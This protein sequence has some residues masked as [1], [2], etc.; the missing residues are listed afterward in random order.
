MKNKKR[1][2]VMSLLLIASIAA[3]AFGE[4]IMRQWFGLSEI[5]AKVMLPTLF[6][7]IV[8]LAMFL[9]IS[10]DSVIRTVKNSGEKKA[11]MWGNL[12]GIIFGIAVV[13]FFCYPAIDKS[14]KDL[15]AGDAYVAG[16]VESIVIPTDS[17]SP[18]RI[19]LE[20]DGHVY[21]LWRGH[22]RYIEVGRTCRFKLYK[23][24]N[25]LYFLEIV[26]E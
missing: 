3:L 21:K 20:D 24:L 18:T 23:N 10:V 22:N 14:L 7:P 26:E 1:L 25:F 4:T 5:D 9:F 2:I 19:T 8:L 6:S 17:D 12:L 11:R 13:S 16:I 15:N